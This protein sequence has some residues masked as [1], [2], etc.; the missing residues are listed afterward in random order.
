MVHVFYSIHGARCTNQDTPYASAS[1]WHEVSIPYDT[2]DISAYGDTELGH[3]AAPEQSSIAAL[4]SCQV[5]Q[6]CPDWD[7]LG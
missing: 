4:L 7:R 6:A 3:P 1:V 2:I 5:A